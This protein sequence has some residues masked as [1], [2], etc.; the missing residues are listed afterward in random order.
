MYEVFSACR[1]HMRNE[2]VL[3]GEFTTTDGYPSSSSPV[4]DAIFVDLP[5]EFIN[6]HADAFHVQP[7]ELTGVNTHSTIIAKGSV[8]CHTLVL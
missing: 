8:Y 6:G 7:A 5:I 2:F 1:Q 4:C 3:H